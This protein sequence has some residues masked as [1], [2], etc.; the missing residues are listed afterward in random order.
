MSNVVAFKSTRKG[1]SP[2]K[3]VSSYKMFEA[4]SEMWG[5]DFDKILFEK[6]KKESKKLDR[7][8]N[9]ENIRFQSNLIKWFD[10][11]KIESNHFFFVI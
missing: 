9:K 7:A 2:K 8:V 10:S 3:T 11:I 5:A 6:D 4:I 1:Y